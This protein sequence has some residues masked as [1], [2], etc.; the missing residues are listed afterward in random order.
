MNAHKMSGQAREFHQIQKFVAACRR[1]WPGAKIVPRSNVATLSGA[2]AANAMNL[3]PRKTTMS[4]EFN[5]D[6][7]TP[8]EADMASMYGSKYL[9]V[10]DIG[11]RKIRA[12]IVKV[13]KEE[14]RQQNGSTRKKAILFFANLDKGLVL[15]AVNK[16]EL[17]EKLGRSPAAWINAEIGLFAAATTFGGKAIQGLRLRVIYK[18]GSAAAPAP[19]PAPQPTAAEEAPWPEESGDPGFAA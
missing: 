14:Q 9:S 3:H 8:S 7:N 15:N 11:D 4:D 19:K 18:P 17:D 1:Q 2:S 13:G 6:I 16:A 10:A 12:K 5:E